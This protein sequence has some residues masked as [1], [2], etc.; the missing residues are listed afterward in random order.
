MAN[1]TPS[2]CENVTG[3]MEGAA[4]G[5]EHEI[6]LSGMVIREH[7]LCRGARQNRTW[8]RVLGADTVEHPRGECTSVV[9]LAMVSGMVSDL[10]N[11]EKA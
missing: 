10:L 4:Y 5:I 1:V 2:G 9:C 11:T 8:S 3:R 7:A 6:A